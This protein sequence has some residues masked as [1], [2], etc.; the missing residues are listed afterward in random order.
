MENIALLAAGLAAMRPDDGR[1]YEGSPMLSALPHAPVASDRST[2]G[3]RFLRLKRRCQ[4]PAVQHGPT[5]W[6]AG[7][8]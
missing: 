6:T 8:P 7:H 3:E 5:G 4:N 1:R 2:L